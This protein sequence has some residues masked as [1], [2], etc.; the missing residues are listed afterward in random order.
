MFETECPVGGIALVFDGLDYV[1][2]SSVMFN[3]SETNH[4]FHCFIIEVTKSPSEA[5]ML[6]QN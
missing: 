4:L 1:S 3:V 5:V 6:Y 2:C